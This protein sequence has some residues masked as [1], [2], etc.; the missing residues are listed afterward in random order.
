MKSFTQ[1]NEKKDHIINRLHALSQEEKE[2]LIKFFEKN[3][4]LE[5]KINWNNKNLTFKDFKEVLDT[6][7][8]TRLE[9][10]VKQHGVSG[11]REGKD[12]VDCTFMYDKH[13]YGCWAYA[14]LNHHASRLIASDK[15]GSV[16]G[17]WC[18]AENNDYHW[19]LYTR[20]GIVL[21]YLIWKH[22]GDKLAIAINPDGDI[23]V[24]DAEDVSLSHEQ[25][26]TEHKDILGKYL[27][28]I[29]E[30]I[31]AKIE[32][33]PPE[34]FTKANPKNA[35]WHWSERNPNHF[36]MDS[37]EW[38][39]GIFQAGTIERDVIF[40]GGEFQGQT[41]NG[42]FN[43][44]IFSSGVFSGQWFDGEWSTKHF[45]QWVHGTDAGG[46]EWLVPPTLWHLASSLINDI[47]KHFFIDEDLLQEIIKEHPTMCDAIVKACNDK[48]MY[49]IR[50]GM[51]LIKDGVYYEISNAIVD[52][53]N[54]Q[55]GYNIRFNG[56]EIHECTSEV[57]YVYCT[58]LG[59][60]YKNIWDSVLD[61][62]TIRKGFFY[63][64]AHSKPWMNHDNTIL[65]GT[66]I[67]QY[68][69]QFK[70]NIPGTIRNADFE[71]LTI[72]SNELI[73]CKFYHCLIDDNNGKTEL[74][75]CKL[76]FETKMYNTKEDN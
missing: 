21:I 67:S 32:V 43:G 54:D 69:D 45:P 62:C 15:V 8:K 19:S 12:Y 63:L 11:L 48:K 52:G 26:G 53:F 9:K 49:A 57:R 37:G 33:L 31:R 36:I 14:P 23:E 24:F 3:P 13:N 5:S 65:G 64:V 51:R 25:L 66:F 35:K 22:D 58:F 39:N 4:H 75:N 38:T 70:V 40:S 34:W 68:G 16:T 17:R 29:D 10:Q 28:F 30:H 56:C 7:S 74:K 2:L 72:M 76:D 1:L 50:G 61:K 59:G 55:E 41:F 71:N 18:T 20:G 73:G 44:G 60:I 42:K 27:S 47:P 46:Y 6:V